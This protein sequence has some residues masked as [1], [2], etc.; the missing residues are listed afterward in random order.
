M[1]KRKKAVFACC[2]ITALLLVSGCNFDIQKIV[3]SSS[4]KENTPL[5]KVKIVFTDAETL[6]TYVKSL[7][8]NE[9]GKVYV[10]GSSLNYFY[11]SKGNVVGSYNYQRVLYI[12]VLPEQDKPD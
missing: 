10:G 8:I 3:Q 6:E 9:S 12:K 4:E 7:G 2:I 11:D 1:L 5:I